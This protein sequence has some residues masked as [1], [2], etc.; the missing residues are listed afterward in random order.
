MLT[1][2]VLPVLAA[3][4]I[5]LSGCATLPTGAAEGSASRTYSDSRASIWQRVLSS[6][7]RNSMFVRQA[8]M[9][10]GLVAVDREI[11]PSEPV[12]LFEDSIFSWADC[13]S[14]GLTGRVVRQRVQ[15]NYVIRPEAD[16]RTTV[17]L[18]ARFQEL[19]N[20]TPAKK[21]EWID[22][23]STGMLERDMLEAIYYDHPAA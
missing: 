15:L 17:T 4:A 20:S 5:I 2:P 8:D 1:R 10:N 9:E 16:G 21:P 13:G 3:A 6:S 11:V 19:R 23:K 7:A 18:N 12:Q 22:C 14:R